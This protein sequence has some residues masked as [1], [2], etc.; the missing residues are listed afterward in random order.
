M[1]D[2]PRITLP[3]ILML[4]TAGMRPAWGQ[5]FLTNPSFEGEPQDATVPQ[6]WFPCREGTTPDILPGFWGVHGEPSEGET[7]LGLITR[8]DGS[9]ESIGQRLP[10]TLVPGE[11]YTF[12]LDLSHA[13]TYAGYSQAIRLR[14]WGGAG[15]CGKEQ[16]LFDSGPIDHGDWVTYK[17]EFTVK[18]PV[19][20]ILLEAWFP[21]E[22]QIV[23]G[24]V[25]IDNM[26]PVSKC[27][28]AMLGGG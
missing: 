15:H 18:A 27:I 6:G 10:E 3:L 1:L 22:G 25:L 21:V 7:Y 11:C 4:A 26:G 16:L 23:R 28:R 2:L 20:Y 17:P 9:W 19:R 24:N 5:A 13:S 14:V 12:S 8:E